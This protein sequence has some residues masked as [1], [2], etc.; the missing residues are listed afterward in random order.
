M[1]TIDSITRSSSLIGCTLESLPRRRV[2]LLLFQWGTDPDGNAT[3]MIAILPVLTVYPIK[4]NLVS[5]NA[6][7][8]PPCP[9]GSAAIPEETCQ[10]FSTRT[11]ISFSEQTIS[12]LSDGWIAYTYNNGVVRWPNSPCYFRIYRS[13][14]GYR[15]FPILIPT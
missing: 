13:V 6:P 15:W 10:A 2:A 9:V 3:C 7:E 11:L 1:I 8:F 4:G 5:G 12:G 14:Y